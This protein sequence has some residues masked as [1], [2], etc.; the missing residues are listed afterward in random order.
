MTVSA[1]GGFCFKWSGS[2]NTE[3]VR[4]ETLDFNDRV[5]AAK[6]ERNQVL[7]AVSMPIH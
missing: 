5:R 7:G 2:A 4:N 3:S 1:S 6:G